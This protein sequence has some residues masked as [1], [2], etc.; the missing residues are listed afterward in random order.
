MNIKPTLTG[1][2][3]FFVWSAAVFGQG[4]PAADF[5]IAKISRNLVATPQYTYT[6]AQQVEAG[7]KRALRGVLRQERLVITTFPW[8]L[9]A[10][11]GIIVIACRAPRR[12]R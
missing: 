8:L 4:R 7:S 1:F 2:A 11:V 3:C 5:Q 6:G 9:P 10:I 12:R